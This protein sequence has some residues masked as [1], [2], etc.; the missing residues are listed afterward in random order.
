MLLLG[1]GQATGRFVGRPCR[2]GP[3]VK[4]EKTPKCLINF[5]DFYVSLVSMHFSV[6]F[7]A[8]TTVNGYN[9]LRWIC[10]LVAQ[11]FEK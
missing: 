10:Y 9:K 6:H 4:T 5:F 7:F 1:P 8:V 3:S 11:Y 2:E